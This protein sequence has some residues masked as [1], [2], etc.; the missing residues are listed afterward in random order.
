MPENYKVVEHPTLGTLEFPQGMDDAAIV[1]AIKKV[2]GVKAAPAM[3]TQPSTQKPGFWE[4]AFKDLVGGG[5]TWAENL[6]RGLEGMIR[7]SPGNMEWVRDPATGDFAPR[8]QENPGTALLSAKDL[9]EGANWW[10]GQAAAVDTKAPKLEEISSL[11]DAM[12]FSSKAILGNAANMVS[13]VGTGGVTTFPTSIGEQY[14]NLQEKGIEDPGLA[15]VVGAGVSVLEAV[16]PLDI[17]SRILGR[18]GVTR[19]A[20]KGVGQVL[21]SAG[22]SATQEGATEGLQEVVGMTGESYAGVGPTAQEGL[23]RVANAA[24]G[25]AL[26]GG[27]MGGVTSMIE[28]DVAPPPPPNPDAEAIRNPTAPPPPPGAPAQ[29]ELFPLEDPAVDETASP[30]APAA[31]PG[32]APVPTPTPAPLELNLNPPDRDLET[33]GDFT[34]DYTE[35]TIGTVKAW[36]GTERSTVIAETQDGRY[37]LS[38]KP[39]TDGTTVSWTFP[40]FEQAAWV[41]KNVGER[42]LTRAEIEQLRGMPEQ[43]V[44]NFLY[45]HARPERATLKGYSG[46]PITLF[47]RDETRRH[48]NARPLTYAQI[49]SI[50]SNPRMVQLLTGL[51]DI[52]SMFRTVVREKGIN[53]V[54]DVGFL[55]SPEGQHYGYN[56]VGKRQIAINLSTNTVQKYPP[57][58]MATS[59]V[60]TIIHEFAH[61][62]VHE[63]N[64]QFLKTENQITGKLLQKY[65]EEVIA[66]SAYF[67]ESY[68]TP[69]NGAIAAL[70]E[71]LQDPTAPERVDSRILSALRSLGRR[72][73]EVVAREGDVGQSFEQLISGESEGQVDE[74]GSDNNA[75]HTRPVVAEFGET[76]AQPIWFSRLGNALFGPTGI[77]GEAKQLSLEQLSAVANN[78]KRYGVRPDEVKWTGLKVWLGGL[79]EQGQKKISREE[80]ENWFER[81]QVRVEEQLLGDSHRTVTLQMMEDQEF[82]VQQAYDKYIEAL[83]AGRISV[84]FEESVEWQ[85]YEYQRLKTRD[86]RHKYEL[87]SAKTTNAKYKDYTSPGPQSNYSELLMIWNGAEY[88]TPHFNANEIAHARFN[89]RDTPNG[90]VLFIEEVQSDWH[91]KGREEGYKGELGRNFG[92]PPQA[93]FSNSWHELALKR[94]I[95]WAVDQGLDGIAWTPSKMQVERYE[96]RLRAVVKG[97]SWAGPANKRA[98]S[99]ATTTGKGFNFYVDE[100]GKI[101]SDA[102][103]PSEFEGKNLSEVLGANAANQ[104]LSERHGKF[105]PQDLTIG[106][107]QYKILYDK[108]IPKFLQ[109]YLKQWGIGLGRT[110]IQTINAGAAKIEEGPMGGFAITDEAGEH[111]FEDMFA[112]REEAEKELARRFGEAVA[113]VPFFPLNSSI[114]DSVRKGQPLL[115]ELPPESRVLGMHVEQGAEAISLREDP[116]DAENLEAAHGDLDNY[117]RWSKQLSTLLQLGFR[118]PHIK[119]LQSFIEHLRELVAEKNNWKYE[120]DK[121]LK[122]WNRLG[123]AQMSALSNFLFE[124]TAESDKFKRRLSLEELAALAKKHNL[125][126]DAE[127]VYHQIDS[128]FRSVLTA[129]KETE[130]ERVKQRIGA[131]NVDTWM[132][133]QGKLEKEF[134][135]ILDRNYFPYAR[136]GTHV[137]LVKAT[138]DLEF[139]GR[140]YRAGNTV[141]MSTYASRREMLEM[142]K[143]AKKEFAVDGLQ[144][145][146]RK[147]PDEVFAFQGFP[148]HMYQDM[149]K[150]LG[151]NEEQ[152]DTAKRFFLNLSPS[153]SF[154]QHL[155]RRRGIAGFSNDAQR[156]FSHYLS[157]AA[158]HVARSKHMDK[159]KIDVS[160]LKASASQAYKET[161]Q[162]NLRDQIG[163]HVEK[164]LKTVENP[165]SDLALLRGTIFSMYFAFVPVQAF[166][167]TLQLPMMTYPHLSVKYGPAKA[168]AALAK[169]MFK[170]SS[171]FNF[172]GTAKW[173]NWNLDGNPNLSPEEKGAI[174]KGIR[175]GFINESF[176]V[177]VASLS[178]GSV[179]E[180]M[181]PFSWRDK[182][183]VDNIREGSRIA[184]DIVDLGIAPF[185][186]SEEWNRR[187][188]FL[189]A[190]N[191]EREVSQNEELAFKEGRDTIDQTMFEYASFNRPMIARAL[192]NKA[193]MF[194]IF[195]AFQQHSL[196][197]YMYGRGR[198]PAL[199]TLALFAGLEGLPLVEDINEIL[200]TFFSWTVKNKRIDPRKIL[201]LA[202]SNIMDDPDIVMHGL[203]RQTMGLGYIPHMPGW[204]LSPKLG[205]GR[206]VPGVA[207]AMQAMRGEKKGIEAGAKI[208]EEWLGV[209]GSMGMNATRAAIDFSP[210]SARWRQQFLP[211]AIRNILRTQQALDA[212]AY[213]DAQG[214]PLVRFDQTDPTQL[215]EVLGQSLGLRPTRLAVE[216]EVLYRA[217]Q[218]DAFFLARKEHLMSQLESALLPSKRDPEAVAEAKRALWH[219]QKTMPPGY[220]FESIDTLMQSLEARKKNNT[221]R[222]RGLPTQ[223]RW[224]KLVQEYRS[225]YPSVR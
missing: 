93:P 49:D 173:S 4:T 207:P 164:V 221:L 106:G 111:D 139:K 180:E 120:G 209:A 134:A 15:S 53:L 61:D 65:D 45:E 162:G 210:Q 193:G 224:R 179:L 14:G 174:E 24:V 99:I 40:S 132:I 25:G 36:R 64:T 184:R 152:A 154:I 181:L 17:A 18:A 197:Y 170:V 67:K 112:T 145:G 125:G 113:P 171:G 41:G 60:T 21:A 115:R 183:G 10:K 30:E 63:H 147:L 214:Q 129:L 150:S 191:L 211:A 123:K 203:A 5:M 48:G 186:M 131:Q 62:Y 101:F 85:E 141:H 159:L 76:L 140:K 143:L 146:N 223:E 32:Q 33:Y 161:G 35:T 38:T 206:V 86:L 119:Q 163:E 20:G 218:E 28:K 157:S 22:R 199:L 96:G 31:A 69:Y 55:F 213:V 43:E 198:M 109:K 201:R 102:A 39:T 98:V 114:R 71:L 117:G 9:R 190:Y 177:E 200:T 127:R 52:S 195:K 122:N 95:R 74:G 169:A 23:S 68:A 144:V 151:L 105:E 137:V 192:N 116:V 8:Q 205:M 121:V 66:M 37:Q 19:A 196:W 220:R 175:A 165:G 189:A 11:E 70:T 176:A 13:A 6:N 73:G 212:E 97:I 88:T 107:E 1:A 91:Q 188:A 57:V 118:N 153:Q 2:E 219:F 42:S 75:I 136:F 72:P 225:M 158:G 84:K 50:R 12:R 133:E 135:K 178:N 126:E 167:N 182:V 58:G 148:A 54:S 78:P 29:T 79:H 27:F 56:D 204:D 142:E 185:R 156:V 155:R 217:S 59:F 34:K 104:I 83:K 222:E 172:N 160:E 81:H 124:V 194:L 187:V 3:A 110:G 16:T 47:N 51:N 208:A 44:Y 149:V 46:D 89:V 92:A 7:S 87:E 202:L 216:Q 103:Y 130:M 215:V 80:A 94:L 100:A 138:K 90:K 82:V 77:F 166:V 108:E 26:S 168:A 128:T